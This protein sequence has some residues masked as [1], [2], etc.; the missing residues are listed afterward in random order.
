[1]ETLYGYYSETQKNNNDQ[2]Y[3]YLNEQGKNTMVTEVSHK[4]KDNVTEFFE[5]NCYVGI[6][7]KFVKSVGKLR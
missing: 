7:N 4:K 3:I 2:Y 1:M 5:D 6:V